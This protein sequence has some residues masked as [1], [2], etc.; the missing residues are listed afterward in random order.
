MRLP[1]FTVVACALLLGDTVLN[2]TPTL[3]SDTYYNG[4]SQAQKNAYVNTMLQQKSQVTL[5]IG[6]LI[7]TSNPCKF[8][9]EPLVGT[10]D[11]EHAKV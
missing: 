6:L 8:M 1:L 11:P 4:L 7:P 10:Q 9:Y 3:G 5:L 2:Q